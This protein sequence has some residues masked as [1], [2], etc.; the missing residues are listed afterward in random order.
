MRKISLFAI[1]L[2]FLAGCQERELA[3]LVT[4]DA[5]P[6]TVS[7][8]GVEN[9][10]GGAKITYSL[11]G[12]PDLLYVVAEYAIRGGEGRR[13]AKSSVYKNHIVLEGFVSTE[14]QEVILYA[15]NRSEN[16]SEPTS[17]TIQPLKAPIHTVFESLQVAQDFGGVNL[18]FVNEQRREYVL[19]TLIKDEDNEWKTYD[20]LYTSAAEWR[21]N[22]RGLPPEET[23]FAFLFSDKWLNRSD[24]LFQTLTPMFEIELDKGIWQHYPLNN[25]YFTPLYPAH[26]VQNLWSGRT[27]N[28]F[29]LQP[30]DGIELP[31]WVTIDLGQKAIFSRFRL[32]QP[33]HNNMENWMY[34]NGSPRKYEIW[35]SNDPSQDGSWDSWVKLAEFESI[36][37]SGLPL[38]QLSNEDRAQSRAGEDSNFPQLSEAYRYIRFTVTETW[39]YTPIIRVSE[40]TLWGQPTD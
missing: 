10:P 33:T 11:P 14:P 1:A 16:R 23:E 28:Y 21:H 38:G 6:G 39:G 13:I 3:P 9:L 7:N 18:H 31:L 8:V 20:R 26:P 32:N 12:D 35:G 29:F 19:Y 17:V 40:L 27:S 36:K 15:V 25:D 2:L 24:T 30:Y 34:T 22:V 5:K 4:S 37:P